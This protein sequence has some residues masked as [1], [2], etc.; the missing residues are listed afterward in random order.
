MGYNPQGVLCYQEKVRG[1]PDMFRFPTLFPEFIRGASAERP[2]LLRGKSGCRGVA[3]AES[4]G[5]SGFS[6]S[7]PV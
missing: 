4:K 5:T 3:F 7:C 6:L 2:D 1:A